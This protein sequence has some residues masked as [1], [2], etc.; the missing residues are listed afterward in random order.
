MLRSEQI[1]R[2]ELSDQLRVS[3]AHMQFDEVLRNFPA[4][5]YNTRP[6]NLTYTFWHVLEHVRFC[7]WDLID[8]AV[9]PDYKS[10]PFPQGVWPPP[11]EMVD[12]ERWQT[13]ID[14]FHL[15]LDRMA[16]FLSDPDFPMFET[17]AWA[18]EPHHTPFR[19]F[20]VA[21]DHNAYHLGELAILRQV[22]GLWNSVDKGHFG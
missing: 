7:Q 21:L 14:D 15:D 22:M 12:A 6:P 20:M 5:H 8:Y 11:D 19:C 13:T 17:P 3:D 18:W 2:G 4:E 9:N 16:A 10:V 1:A